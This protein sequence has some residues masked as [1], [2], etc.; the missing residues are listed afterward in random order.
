[1]P[2]EICPR[3]D[4]SALADVERTLGMV[5]KLAVSR[6]VAAGDSDKN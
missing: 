4:L 3:W 2:I 1:M 6:R 5:G